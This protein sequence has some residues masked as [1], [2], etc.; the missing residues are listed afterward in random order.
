MGWLFLD[1]L[2][3]P[4]PP[5]VRSDF[6]YK[7]DDGHGR[8]SRVLGVPLAEHLSRLKH[9]RTIALELLREIPIED[10]RRLRH[11]R[12]EDYAVTPEWAVF[13]LVEH[14]A[15]HAFQISSLKARATRLF[16]ANAHP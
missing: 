7:R 8:L 14:E 2:E 12:D 11:P 4:F 5:Q 6:P 1:I 9:S 13:H 16:A 3:K 15:G 10:W